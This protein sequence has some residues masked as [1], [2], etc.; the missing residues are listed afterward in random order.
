MLE[1]EPASP[2]EPKAAAHA[3][4]AP[5]VSGTPKEGAPVASAGAPID[6]VERALALALEAA[7]AAQRL[8]LVPG[9]VAELGERRRAREHS[10]VPS[11]EQAR[12]KKRGDA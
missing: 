9:I 2:V 1:A 3:A 5:A 12:S 8:D 4:G 6:P 10:D 7:V 11:L